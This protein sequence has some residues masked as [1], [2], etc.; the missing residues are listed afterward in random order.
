MKLDPSLA[1]AALAGTTLLPA[2]PAAA[3]VPLTLEASGVAQVTEVVNAVGPVLR[4][5]TQAAGS[6]S[7]GLG[8]YTSTDVI[9]MATGQGQGE[10]RFVADNGDELHGSFEV[11]AFPTATPGTLRLVGHTVFHGGTGIFAGAS[12]SAD[13]T[14]IGSFVSETQATVSFNHAG[15]VVLVP[16][17][18]TGALLAGGLACVAALRSRRPPPAEGA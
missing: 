18:S 3:A 10:N 17:P 12:G 2:G 14:G 15:S 6:G 4:F 9:D 1:A 5:A 11:Q 7:L 16:E 8:G 13:F